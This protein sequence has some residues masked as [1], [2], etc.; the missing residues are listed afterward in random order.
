LQAPRQVRVGPACVQVGGTAASS[1]A[2]GATTWRAA[3]GTTASPPVRMASRCAPGDSITASLQARMGATSPAAAST[4]AS[5]PARMAR[6]SAPGESTTASPRARTAAM[7]PAA[8]STTAS[9]QAPMGRAYAPEET[10]T[11]SR[12]VPTGRMLLVADC[13]PERPRARTVGG[14]VWVASLGG[15]SA[16]ELL[17]RIFQGP[18]LFRRVERSSFRLS[19]RC[20][21]ASSTA[22][23]GISRGFG[24]DAKHRIIA[25]ALRA[26]QASPR[27]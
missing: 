1:R 19:R 11:V 26:P 21:L 3:G 4:T 27:P 2:L 25:S 20:H 15:T 12:Q 17:A 10:T 18:L 8:V 22:S 24:L 13:S 6:G 23:K 7:S 16:A 14:S 5:P 9:P